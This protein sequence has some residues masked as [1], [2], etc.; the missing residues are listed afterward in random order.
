V[1]AENLFLPLTLEQPGSSKSDFYHNLNSETR[2]A[3]ENEPITINMH[4]RAVTLEQFWNAESF[5]ELAANWHLV[6]SGKDVDGKA[7]AAVVEHKAFFF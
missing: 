7:F 6:A 2:T 1:R 3:L 5:P 4:G